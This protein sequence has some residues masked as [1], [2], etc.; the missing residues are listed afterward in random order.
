MAPVGLA[1]IDFEMSV[2]CYWCEFLHA[3]FSYRTVQ[4]NTSVLP[5]IYFPLHFHKPPIIE[6]LLWMW[7]WTPNPFLGIDT[8]H[9][10]R[11]NQIMKENMNGWH[12]GV[13]WSIRRAKKMSLMSWVLNQLKLKCIRVIMRLINLTD[14]LKL[15]SGPMNIYYPLSSLFP[16]ARS[17]SEVRNF[18]NM[19]REP[20][21]V[22]VRLSKSNCKFV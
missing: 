5:L 14:L 17:F 2:S 3:I 20:H 15:T 6:P 12:K 10:T 4:G 1:L 8:Y 16:S 19:W 11:R 21:L 18:K 9:K 7:N 13:V 22:N